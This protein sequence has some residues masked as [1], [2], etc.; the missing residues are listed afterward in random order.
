MQPTFLPWLGYFGLIE[1]A[2]QFVFLDDVQFSKQSWQSRN[3]IRG[4]KGEIQTLSLSVARKPSKPLINEARLADTGFERGLLQ[5]LRASYAKSGFGEL[6]HSLT[7]E[8]FRSAGQSLCDLNIEF[9]T[10]M[11]RVCGLSTTFHRSR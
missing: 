8:A 6:A 7:A 1:L 9:I 10:Q 4:Q 5:N 3:R 2:D 11:S